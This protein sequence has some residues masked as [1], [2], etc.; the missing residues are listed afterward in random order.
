V[1]LAVI[2]AQASELAPFGAGGEAGELVA[3]DVDEPR[4][5]AMK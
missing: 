5:L 2:Q 4:C 1:K 3:I